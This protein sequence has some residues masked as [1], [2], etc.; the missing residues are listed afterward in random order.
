MS[1]DR[2]SVLLTAEPSFSPPHSLIVHVRFLITSVAQY[3]LLLLSEID[4][5]TPDYLST[6][7]N[8]GYSTILP[9]HSPA[10]L[11]SPRY[12]TQFVM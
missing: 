9:R 12:S 2:Q 8:G 11:I 3:I 5:P 6:R 4:S 7:L 10:E 1:P